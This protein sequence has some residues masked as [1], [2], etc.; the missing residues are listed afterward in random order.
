LRQDQ[1]WRQLPV[2]VLTGHDQVLAD[3]GRSYLAPYPELR[4]ADAV[5]G[6]PLETPA[7][8]STLD[9]LLRAA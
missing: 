3:A 8:L 7:L 5:L 6:K 9:R 2:I 4:G 1:R